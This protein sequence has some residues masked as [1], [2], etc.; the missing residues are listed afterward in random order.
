MLLS[1][2]LWL[3]HV[4][5]I[6]LPMLLRTSRRK[7][8]R[9]TMLQYASSSR[10]LL[11]EDTRA[12]AFPVGCPNI[13]LLVLSCSNF[14]TTTDSHLTRFARWLNLKSSHKAKKSRNDTYRSKHLTASGQSFLILY[15]FP[16]LSKS[17]SWD[18]HAMLRS[19]ETY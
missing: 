14:M 16:C 11:I 3:R 13:T 2:Y 6:A 10:N 8:F 15:C 9:V 18:T 19:L 4:I 1:I 17:A 12:N 5:S 7:L